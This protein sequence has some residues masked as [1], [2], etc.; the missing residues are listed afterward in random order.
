MKRRGFL[1]M[2]ASVLATGCIETGGQST[3]AP[4]DGPPT[5]DQ[6]EPDTDGNDQPDNRTSAGT[7]G[8][9]PANTPIEFHPEE[10][11]KTVSVGSRSAVSNPDENLPRAFGIWNSTDQKREVSVS[12][13]E[14]GENEQPLLA[15]SYTIP[16]DQ[17]LQIVLE[18]PATYTV[19]IRLR[20][21]GA[22]LTKTV[23]RTEFTCNSATTQV[24]I[25]EDGTLP[26]TIVSTTA[27]CDDP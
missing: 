16:A 22:T 26:H 12:V 7:S 17:L 3:T 25:E 24:A 1:A 15:S 20:Q 9:N 5:H 10:F 4:D 27:V 6:T 11:Y 2:T 13:E 21:S 8:D 23:A 14:D 18:E 19:E